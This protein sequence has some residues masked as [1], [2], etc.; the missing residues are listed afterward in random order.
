MTDYIRSEQLNVIRSRINNIRRTAYLADN[1][2]EELSVLSVLEYEEML[3]NNLPFISALNQLNARDQENINSY[4]ENKYEFLQNLKSEFL[5]EQKLFKAK[6]IIEKNYLDKLVRR[7]KQKISFLNNFQENTKVLFMHSFE[8]LQLI[9]RS[10]YSKNSLKVCS[11]AGVLT[12]PV[13]SREKIVT[14]D[15]R[16]LRG[17]NGIVGNIFTGE[18]K[19]LQ[20]VLSNNENI[21]EYSKLDEGPITLILD[22]VFTREKIVNEFLVKRQSIFENN[23]LKI[24]KVLYKD[25]EENIVN[26][27]DLVNLEKQKFECNANFENE[28]LNVIHL[29]AKAKKVEMHFESDQYVIKNNRKLFSIDLRQVEFY[30]NAF[31]KSGNLYFE[32]QSVL[33][34]ESGYSLVLSESCYPRGVDKITKRIKLNDS[35]FIDCSSSKLILD[36]EIERYSLMYSLERSE[37]LND[38]DL[39]EKEF[40]VVDFDSVQKRFN[41]SFSPNE[42]IVNNTGLNFKT[43]QPNIYKRNSDVRQANKIGVLAGVETR[44]KLPFN[45]NQK[46]IKIDDASFYILNEELPRYF[47]KEEVF[48]SEVTHGFYLSRNGEDLYIKYSGITNL[49]SFMREVSVK[50]LLKETRHKIKVKEN[51]L[52]VEILE[53]FDVTKNN[54]SFFDKQNLSYFIENVYSQSIRAG[55]YFLKATKTKIDEGSIT[56]SNT[57]GSVI[58][59]N[60]YIIEFISEGEESHLYISEANGSSCFSNENVTYT[61]G[62][63]YFNMTNNDNFYIWKEEENIKGLAVEK[64]SIETKQ[65]TALVQAGV[66]NFSLTEDYQIIPGSLSLDRNLFDASKIVLEKPYI[67]GFN[68]F[69]NLGIIENEIV[70]TIE[71]VNGKISFT[72]H[73]KPYTNNGFKILVKKNNNFISINDVNV[74]G[75]IVELFIDDEYSE[76]YSIEYFY[77]KEPLVNTVLYSVDYKNGKVFFSEPTLSSGGINASCIDIKLFYHIVNYVT[78]FSLN[79][80]QVGVEVGN[81]SDYNDLIK[82]AWERK[83]ESFSFESMSDYYSPIVYDVKMEIS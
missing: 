6:D 76:N 33:N 13:S 30:S 25:A 37:N 49:N 62:Y 11:E 52:L 60:L 36:N 57:D 22:F 38:V 19:L 14:S 63:N 59:P 46:K 51:Y 80:N 42:F 21:F 43:Y 68:E 9:D 17:S 35:G 45:L 83:K 24:K 31:N 70:P 77:E 27:F 47:S 26:C 58:D 18:N 67:N 8:N 66:Y 48:D 16:V 78:N 40:N 28:G 55:R 41:S 3:K 2:H 82:F 71:R 44:L 23:N 61:I 79:G 73:K 74:N 72:S 10:E 15:I 12:L 65:I 69:L 81:M 50:M 53:D 5:E 56:V 20:N 7:I 54:I 4:F 29:P 1:L 32:E 39:E 64:D 34:G 75:R